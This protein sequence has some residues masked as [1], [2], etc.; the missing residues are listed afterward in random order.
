MEHRSSGHSLHGSTISPMFEVTRQA[1]S[2]GKT[3]ARIKN[4]AQRHV[5]LITSWLMESKPCAFLRGVH[6]EVLHR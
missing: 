5:L 4:I 1:P 3:T 6:G 2:D